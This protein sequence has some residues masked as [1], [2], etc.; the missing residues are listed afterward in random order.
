MKKHIPTEIQERRYIV[1]QK[2]PLFGTLSTIAVGFDHI[3]D[4]KK[5][6][7]PKPYL[8][9]LAI[10]MTISGNAINYNNSGK[11]IHT[12][13][14]MMIMFPKLK[15]YE[16]AEKGDWSSCW[17]LIGGPIADTFIKELSIN[18]TAIAIENVPANVR[19]DMLEACRMI[20]KQ[21]QDWQWNW[22]DHLFSVLNFVRKSLKSHSNNSSLIS[23]AQEIML[24]N[25]SVALTLNEIAERLNVSLSTLS[26]SFK[27]ETGMSPGR[28]YKTAKIDKAKQ[29]L[30]NGLNVKETSLQMG[31]E[32]PFHFSK[33]FKQIENIS[34]SKFQMQNSKSTLRSD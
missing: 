8:D 21:P 4:G 16:M 26:H 23:K 13:G 6:D 3:K 2:D 1:S 34:P 11:A 20:L 29:L 18:S 12:P 7:C 31:F 30:V 15:F 28:Y 25:L 33:L 19:F 14:S 32:N 9:T 17:F 22:I 5:A 10:E 24:N 27:S